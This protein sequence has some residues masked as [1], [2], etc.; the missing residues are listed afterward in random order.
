VTVRRKLSQWKTG[1]LRFYLPEVVVEV[2]L[3]GVGVGVGVGVWVVEPVG[4][5]ACFVVLFDVDV[6][7]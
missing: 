4:G 5:G 1:N 3:S 6:T 2:D 7:L